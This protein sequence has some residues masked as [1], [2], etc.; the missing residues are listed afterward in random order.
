MKAS[1]VFRKAAEAAIRSPRV[2]SV[3]R[4]LVKNHKLSVW[5]EF[6]EYLPCESREHRCMAL[7]LLAEIAED[8]EC[9]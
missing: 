5:T 9:A 6:R 4:V 3:E 1:E 2:A 8:E 7:L